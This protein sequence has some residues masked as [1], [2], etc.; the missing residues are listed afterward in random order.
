MPEKKTC[1]VIMPFGEKTD[2]GGQQIDFDDVYE[3]LIKPPLE[4]MNVDVI[5]C[6][7]IPSARRLSL[8]Y[9]SV[10]PRSD[11]QWAHDRSAGSIHAALSA[12]K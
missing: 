11:I 5:R 12:A 1:F 6:D 8:D 3:F 10:Q 2:M 4:K 9:G 7:K